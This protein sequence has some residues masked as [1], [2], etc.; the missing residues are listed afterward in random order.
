MKFFYQALVCVFSILNCP[1]FAQCPP[2]GFPQPGN[3]CVTAPVLCENLDGYCATINNSNQTQPFPGCG[4][5]WVLNNDE[6]FAFFAGTTSITIQVTPSNCSQG[7]SMGLQGGIY[8]GCINQVMDVQCQCTEDPFILSSD[9]YVVGEIYWFVL[10]GCSGNVCDYS[11][12]VLSGSTVGVPPDDPGPITG[13]TE[14]CQNSTTSYSITPVD[15]A[16]EY[17]WTL[18]PNIGTISGVIE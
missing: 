9:N 3:T 5:Q 10:D 13:L 7:P 1:L 2:A 8:G 17:N 12:E 16:T 18:T 15:A 11:I 14:V 6:W 4:G